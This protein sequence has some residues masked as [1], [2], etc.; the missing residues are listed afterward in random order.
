MGILLLGQPANQLQAETGAL[1]LRGGDAIMQVHR[2]DE[3]MVRERLISDPAFY[4]NLASFVASECR[5]QADAVE[6]EG[7]SGQ[8][9][10]SQL[11]ELADGFEGVAAALTTETIL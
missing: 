6:A 5:R 10:K 1:E 11:T 9:I 4:R 7:N 2:F 8:V 3:P